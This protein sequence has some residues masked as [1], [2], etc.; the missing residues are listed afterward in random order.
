MMTGGYMPSL[1]P[2]EPNLDEPGTFEFTAR[3]ALQ[4]RAINRFALSLRS[5]AARAAFIADDLA[6]MR[7]F[8]LSDEEITLIRARDWTGLLR[9]GGHLQ[10]ISKIAGAYGLSLWDI[11][12]DNVGCGRDELMAAC[13]RTVAGLPDGAP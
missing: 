11:G 3:R 12:A 8:D 9:A 6:A 13:P 2:P 10:A 1:P 7:P 4:G 5:P